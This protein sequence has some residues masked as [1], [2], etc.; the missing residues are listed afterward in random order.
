MDNNTNIQEKKDI[1]DNKEKRKVKK[2][3][4]KSNKIH[5]IQ[6]NYQVRLKKETTRI[7]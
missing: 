1:K 5:L 7:P 2:S 6:N 4:Q 3:I